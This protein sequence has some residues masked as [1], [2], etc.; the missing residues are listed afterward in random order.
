MSKVI[1]FELSMDDPERA[2]KF[3]SD[4]FGWQSSKWGGPMDYWLVTTGPK[5]EAGID[6]ALMLRSET[7]DRLKKSARITIGVDSVDEALKKIEDSGGKILMP[8]TPV[9]GVGYSASFEDPEGNIVALMQEDP[10]AE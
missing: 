10:S 8:K 3:Y 1:H 4:V 9:P 2:I 7:D 5:E 6:G